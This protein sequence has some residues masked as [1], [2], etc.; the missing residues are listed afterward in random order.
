MYAGADAKGIR[1]AAP[2]ANAGGGPSFMLQRQV[3]TLFDLIADEVKVF[4]DNLDG[5][6]LRSK[7]CILENG[8]RIF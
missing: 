8:I 5:I 4:L 3:L 2:K 7:D 1:P 6:C